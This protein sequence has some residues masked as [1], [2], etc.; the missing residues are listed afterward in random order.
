MGRRR[1]GSL[2]FGSQKVGSKDSPQTVAV[3]NVSGTTV[4]FSSV[5]IGGEFNDF[6]ETNT[7]TV[8][9]LQP[10]SSCTATVTFDPTKTGARSG[11]LDFVL[12]GTVSPRSVSLTGTGT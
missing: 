11:T 12:Q 1:Q 8:R 3:T 6:S 10:G 5:G 7:C 9:A 2:D 4:T